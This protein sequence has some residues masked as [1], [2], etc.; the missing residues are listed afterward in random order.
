MILSIPSADT[1]IPLFV[2]F[3]FVVLRIAFLFLTAP[4]L[5]ASIMPMRIRVAVVVVISSA[6]FIGLPPTVAPSLDVVTLTGAVLGEAAVGAA[7]GLTARLVFSAIEGAGQLAG[8]PM[9]LGFSQMADP[10]SSSN[11]VVTSRF[12]GIIAAL[13]FIGMDAHHV[14]IRLLAGSFRALPPGQIIPSPEAGKTLVKS[15]S[16]VFSGAVQLA[17]PVLLVLLGVMLSIGLL[18]RVAPKV[19]LLVLSFAI[20]IALGLIAMRAALPEMGAWIRVAINRIEPLVAHI[21]G[22][23]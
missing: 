16:M 4:V 7:A 23:F 17:A 10:L 12:L 8:V 9:G 21:L 14:L 22:T 1:V 5:G 11:A 2:T 20:S 6:V 3:S 19:N 15:A 18:A 13:I